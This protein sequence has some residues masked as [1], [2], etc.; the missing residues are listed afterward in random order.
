MD[1]AI[2]VKRGS[3]AGWNNFSEHFYDIEL[4]EVSLAIFGNQKRLWC[5]SWYIGQLLEY[6]L[7]SRPGYIEYMP[8]IVAGTR[9]LATWR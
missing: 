7:R 6:S 1:T 8:G 3:S 5:S 2:S 4:N 9:N